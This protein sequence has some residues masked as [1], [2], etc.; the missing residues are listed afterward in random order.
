MFNERKAAQ[1]AVWLLR[2][3][4]GRMPH[5][6]LIKLMYLAEREAMNRYGFPMTGDD[7]VAMKHGPVP[8][9]T[10]DYVNGLEESGPDGW[11]SWI[12]DKADHE[13]ALRERAAKSD[14]LDELSRADED[15][16]AGVWKRFGAMGKY[17]I[18]DYTH[19]SK[20]C[21]EWIDPEGSS[22]PI[23]FR[24]IFE[25]LGRAPDEAAFLAARIEEQR[26]ID[27]VFASI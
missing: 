3:N 4:Q 15:V 6:K 9:W 10:L 18:R 8:T 7:F 5:L 17:Q 21:P 23:P 24:R 13:V 22:K 25:A 27:K 2:Q 26:Q 19:D 14:V 20:N 12:S 1:V 11:D 16:L